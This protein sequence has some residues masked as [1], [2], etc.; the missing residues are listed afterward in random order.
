[1]K[2][3]TLLPLWSMGTVLLDSPP[4]QYSVQALAVVVGA[5]V[6]GMAVVGVA[7]VGV[8]VGKVDGSVLG[9]LVGDVVEG[10]TL[11]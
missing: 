11:G 2:A 9:R 6:D 5:M 10:T 7:V 3:A 8:S 1:M 4:F